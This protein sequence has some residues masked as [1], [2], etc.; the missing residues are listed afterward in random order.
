MSR[1]L[2]YLQLLLLEMDPSSDLDSAD[3]IKHCE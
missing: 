1:V 2:A 3:P